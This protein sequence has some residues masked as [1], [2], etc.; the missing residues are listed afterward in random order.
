[1]TSGGLLEFGLP[2]VGAPRVHVVLQGGKDV[3]VPLAL[4]TVIIEP[5]ELRVMLL[6]RGH[7]RL[8]TGPHE[9]AEISVAS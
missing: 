1:M 9:V 8:P 5:D 7:L 4:D 2:G 3:Q 6:W